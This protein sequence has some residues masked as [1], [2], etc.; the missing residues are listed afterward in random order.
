[1]QT[2]LPARMLPE[3]QW[4]GT[5]PALGLSREG[6]REAMDQPSEGAREMGDGS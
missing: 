6:A 5:D 4:L 2:S 1:M 3:P